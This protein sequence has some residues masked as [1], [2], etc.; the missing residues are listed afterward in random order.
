MSD[1]K[2]FLDEKGVAYLYKQLS[3]EDYPNNET[4]SGILKAIDE[5]K[6]DREE[7]ILSPNRGAV[8]QVLIVETIDENNKPTTYSLQDMPATTLV[9]FITWEDED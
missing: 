1:T 6:A 8:G 5:T 4:L 7:V 3:L 2:R 9:Q